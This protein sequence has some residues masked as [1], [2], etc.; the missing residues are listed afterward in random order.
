[1]PQERIEE[2]TRFWYA[3]DVE[4]EAAAQEAVEYALMEAGARGT[5]FKGR[6]DRLACVTAYFAAEPDREQIRSARA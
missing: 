6:A 4:L 3:P 1:M 2:A 5:E